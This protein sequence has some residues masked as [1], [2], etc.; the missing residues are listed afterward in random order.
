MSIALAPG[1]FHGVVGPNG[2]GKTTMV[3]LL[4]RF[5]APQQRPDPLRRQAAGR[6]FETAA[7]AGDRPRAPELL[8]QFSVHA[9]GT[10]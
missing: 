8:H 7:G 2:C 1:K 10:W 5:P 6:L 3:D 4:C 9:C